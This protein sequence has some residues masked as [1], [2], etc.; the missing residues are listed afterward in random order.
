MGLGMAAGVHVLLGGSRAASAHRGGVAGR[1]SA[2]CPPAVG[3]TLPGTPRRASARWRQGRRRRIALRARC[4]R[5]D[6][7]AGANRSPCRRRHRRHPPPHPPPSCA[8]RSRPPP[9]FFFCAPP[10]PPAAGGAPPP[11]P[12]AAAQALLL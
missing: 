7:G 3:K 8:P 1:R 6:I 4:H 10:P 11:G 5:R 9:R 12:A 2:L